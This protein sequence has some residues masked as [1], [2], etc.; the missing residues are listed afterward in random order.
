M[1]PLV[2][3]LTISIIFTELYHRSKNKVAKKYEID[4]KISDI[5]KRLR[6]Q[7]DKNNFLSD[8]LEIIFSRTN[9]TN[10]RLTNLYDLIKLLDN[11]I[12]NK[13]IS[14]NQIASP[15]QSHVS[16]LNIQPSQQSQSVN[17]PLS[18]QS[19]LNNYNEEDEERRQNSTI[20]YILKKLEDKALTTRE[21]QQIIGRTREHS[22]RLMKK[23]YDEKL[24]DRDMNTKPFK[25]N[26]TDEGRKLLIKHSVSKNHFPSDSY[27][28]DTS[29]LKGLIEK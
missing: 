6:D 25:Y 15:S 3:T 16:N 20:E 22:S 18:Q 26:I 24:V 10:N 23:L 8:R 7:K 2:S 29:S 12:T 9:E 4:L 17:I 27:Q 28:N 11:N 19:N 5:E 1:I 14:Q 21:I 13:I